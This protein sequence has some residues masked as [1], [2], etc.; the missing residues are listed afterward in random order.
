MKPEPCH[1]GR[2]ALQC[3]RC[4]SIRELDGAEPEPEA[5]T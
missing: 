5:S 1:T 2:K 4:Q 3:G